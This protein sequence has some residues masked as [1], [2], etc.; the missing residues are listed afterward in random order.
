MLRLG[1]SITSETTPFENLFSSEFDGVNDLLNLGDSDTFTFGDGS[2]DT[3]FSLSVWYNSPDVTGS[4]VIT[5][6][7]DVSA[8]REYYLYIGGDDKL[9]WALWDYSTGGYIFSRTN[10]TLTS[11]QGS[12][13]HIAV[14]YD[15]SGANT[16]QAIYINSVSKAVTRS[17]GTIGSGAY[18][19]MENT[20]YPLKIGS[21]LAGNFYEG[22]LDEVSMWS[23]E[24]TSDEVGVIY[25]SGEPTDLS[26]ASG[27]IGWWRMGDT[28]I[29]PTIPDASTNSNNGTMTNMSSGDITTDV[30]PS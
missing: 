2:S 9:Y 28:A 6:S 10:D 24:L 15:G 17:S 11:T 1:N 25:N 26:G 13:T 20:A 7:G 18:V 23:K 4:G 21:L 27:L 16:G 5:K 29:F 30:P 22:D 12:W 8:E 19:A 14:T 3:A